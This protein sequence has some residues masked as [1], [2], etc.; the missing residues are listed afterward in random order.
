MNN[1]KTFTC[2]NCGSRKVLADS[3]DSPPKCCGR[4]M[5]VLPLP[6]CELSTTAEH[7]RLAESIEP[8]DDGRSGA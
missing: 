1:S 8:C 5:T 7:A 6:V 4:Q 3:K 2:E